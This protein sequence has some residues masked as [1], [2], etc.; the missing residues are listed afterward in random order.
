MVLPWA[1]MKKETYFR[2]KC[3]LEPSDL[4]GQYLQQAHCS[5]SVLWPYNGM[6]SVTANDKQV[7]ELTVLAVALS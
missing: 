1:D 7:V 4:K 5:D 2:A 3:Q 6:L